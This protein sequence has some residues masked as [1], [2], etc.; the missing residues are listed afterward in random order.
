M[1]EDLWSFLSFCAIV[2]GVIIAL[3]EINLMRKSTHSELLMDIYHMWESKSLMESR[4]LIKEQKTKEALKKKLKEWNREEKEEYFI[5]FRVCNYFEHIGH[6][7]AKKYMK[8]KDIEDL[9]GP[10]VIKYY[11]IFEDYTKEYRKEDERFNENFENLKRIV[12]PPIQHTNSLR[13][14]P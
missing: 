2:V 13:L 14:D 4:K 5:A 12:E 1:I 3:I 6:L 9:M 8:G 10:S 11:E 7:V